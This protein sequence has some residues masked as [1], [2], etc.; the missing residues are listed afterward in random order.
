MTHFLSFMHGALPDLNSHLAYKKGIEKCRLF[1]SILVLLGET[2]SSRSKRK[3]RCY[4][5]FLLTPRNNAFFI[6]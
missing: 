3:M 6:S 1:T 5:R 4:E 2:A